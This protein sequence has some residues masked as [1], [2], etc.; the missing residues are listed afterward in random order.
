MTHTDPLALP[1]KHDPSPEWSQSLAGG[2]AGIALLHIAHAHAGVGDWGT[3]HQWVAA[4]TRSPVVAD[5]DACGLFRGAPAVAFVLRVAARPEYAAALRTL[6]GH[7]ATLTRHRLDRAHERIERG[8]LPALGE[9]DLING[10]TGIGVYLLQANNTDLLREVLSYLA[11]LV[12]QPVIVDGEKLPGWWTGHGPA[13]QPSI[14]WPGGH[15]NLGL[16]HGLAGPLTVLAS[17]LARGI[18]VTGHGVAVQRIC[19]FLDQ[20]RCGTRSRPWW[21]G[22]ISPNEWKNRTVEQ[23]GPQRPSWCYGTP[24]LARAQQLAALALGDPQRQR[25]A[26]DALAGCL[27]DEEQL[28]QLGGASV[29]HGWAGLVQTT[30]RAAADAGPDSELAALLPHLRTRFEQHLHHQRQPI[31]DG[32]LEGA[33]GVALTRHATADGVS[34]A[35]RWDACLLLAPPTR[36]A[37]PALETLHMEGR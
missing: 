30:R 17:A 10:L 6:D 26:E 4:M 9:F 5:P 16:A 29:C 35:S 22:M 25:H 13:D 11:R 21:P 3:A 24:G 1:P 34:P 7:I 32:L 19:A 23:S 20:W 27:T 8:Q 36:E 31:G 14:D 33:T 12:V 2:A 37:P 18:V 15:S 28:S